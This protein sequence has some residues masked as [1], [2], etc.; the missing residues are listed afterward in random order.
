MP[1]PAEGSHRKVVDNS[2]VNETSEEESISSHQEV[3]LNPQPSVSTNMYM[4]YI[5]A[6]TNGLDSQ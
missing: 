1:R 5:E 2:Q 4:P 3:V 6:T